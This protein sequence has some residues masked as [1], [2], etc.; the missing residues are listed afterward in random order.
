[1]TTAPTFSGFG[2]AKVQ[3]V[4][5]VCDLDIS[6]DDHPL[7]TIPTCPHCGRQPAPERTR[8]LDGSSGKNILT[9]E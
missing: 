2:N 5:H 4:C 7:D 1:M 6:I 8:R 9:I 3:W